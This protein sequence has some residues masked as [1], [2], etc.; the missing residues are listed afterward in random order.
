MFLIKKI[1]HIILLLLVSTGFVFAAEVSK[2]SII[3]NGKIS[4]LE[5]TLNEINQELEKNIWITRYNNYLTYRKIEK[6]LVKIKK[7]AK[8]YGRWKGDRHRTTQIKT[9]GTA[10]RWFL[11]IFTLFSRRLQL[12]QLLLDQPHLSFLHRSFQRHLGFQLLLS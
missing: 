4:E 11:F 3:K 9:T 1:I 6:D 10:C 2:E 7:D 12:P 8:K 5:N